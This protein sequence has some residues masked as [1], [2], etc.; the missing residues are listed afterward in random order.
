MKIK[1]TLI[2]LCLLVLPGCV[3]IK[4]WVKVYERQ[5]LADPIMASNRDPVSSAFLNHVLDAREGARG[6]AGSG[7]GGCGCN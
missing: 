5:D 2:T 1:I 4:P 3:S 6:A 7:G